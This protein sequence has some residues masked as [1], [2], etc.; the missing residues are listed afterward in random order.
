MGDVER[1]PALAARKDRVHGLGFSLDGQ[2]L[3]PHLRLQQNRAGFAAFAKDGDLA[4]FLSRQGV[5]PFQPADFADADAG[6]VEQLQQNPVAP[7]GRGLDQFGD[8]AFLENA[9]CQAIAVGL[10]FDSGADVEGCWGS[11]ER[12]V[13]LSITFLIATSP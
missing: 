3:L 11:M 12:N 7:L 13:E 10:E 6:D 4:A 1:S 2:E 5:A 9:L 8:F